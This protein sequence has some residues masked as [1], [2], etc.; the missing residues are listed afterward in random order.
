MRERFGLVLLTIALLVVVAFAIAAVYSNLGLGGGL[1]FVPALI[2]I[3]GLGKES[4]VAASLV[5]VLAGALAALYQ[6]GKARNIDYRLVGYLSA[7]SCTGAVAGTFFNLSIGE[8]TFRWLFLAV[9]LGLCMWMAFDLYMSIRPDCDDDSKMCTQY[10]GAA[11]G[12]AVFAGF[13]SGAFGIGGGAI[14]V[15]TLVYILCRHV[16]L[17][18]GTSAATIVPTTA[19]GIAIYFVGGS[20]QLESDVWLYVAVLAPV[21]FAGAFMGTRAGIAKLTGKQIKMA[22]LALTVLV[23]VVMVAELAL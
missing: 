15:P 6:H 13:L 4:A 7:G 22:F 18:V 16:K 1:M 20:G 11:I 14:M 3:G 10:I 17:A 5:L 8:D 23:A 12:A 9:V 21:A 2:I 19:I